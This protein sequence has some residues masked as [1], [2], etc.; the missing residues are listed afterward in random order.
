MA[1]PIPWTRAKP[2]RIKNPNVLRL[3]ER[4]WQV[5]AAIDKFTADYG[6]P[7]TSPDLAGMMQ[8]VPISPQ[9]AGDKVN[10]LKTKGLLSSIYGVHRS[11][12]VTDIGKR[13]LAW[14]AAQPKKEPVYY[15]PFADLGME[16]VAVEDPATESAEA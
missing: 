1:T 9:G 12:R 10:K 4:Q 8:P 11:L 14:V 7:P 6:V 3:T 13:A 16:P 15:I 2:R 5:L